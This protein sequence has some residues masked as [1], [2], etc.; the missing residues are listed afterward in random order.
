M[1]ALKTGI[2]S[3]VESVRHRRQTGYEDSKVHPWMKKKAEG[4]AQPKVPLLEGSGVH[5]F[6]SCTQW[7]ILPA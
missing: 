6:V 2:V 5:S 7:L 4:P 3:M 1:A